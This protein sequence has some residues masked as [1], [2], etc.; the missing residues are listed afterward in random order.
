MR[1]RSTKIEFAHTV[2][3]V[4]KDGCPDLYNGVAKRVV[5]KEEAEKH[6]WSHY[7]D[8]K[9]ACPA[10]HIAA[11]YVSNPSIC[12]D[13]RRLADGK[14]PI[15]PKTEHIDDLT[16]N[17]VYVA[18]VASEKFDWSA[19]KK[20][21]LLRAWI[22]T[23]NF[24]KACEVIG[25]QPLHALELL[26]S[27]AEFKADYEDAERKVAQVQS[28]AIEGTAANGDVRTALAM[29]SNKFPQFGAKTSLA[30]RPAVNS[31][32]ARAELTQLLSAARRSI[33]NRSRL[34]SIA[35]AVRGVGRVDSSPAGTAA[36]LV[37][38]PP[39]LGQSHEHSDL[40][41]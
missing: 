20:K 9:T 10:G 19:E 41:S 12:T 23:R 28:W 27:D 7:Y 32:Q 6:G 24:L 40:V 15:Y 26:E 8:G 30:G 4:V 39:V 37:D 5:E 21:Q 38:Q 18:P 11:R 2:C 35:G 3:G 22:N 17:P 13:C 31:E 29:A 16:G 33:A 25:C 14:L 1:K 36:D 34:E